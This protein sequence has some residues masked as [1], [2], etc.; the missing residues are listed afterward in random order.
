MNGNAT[1]TLNVRDVF[2]SRKRRYITEGDGF[3]AEGEFQW[4]ARSTTLTFTYRLNQ[5]KRQER[6]GRGEGGYDMDFGGS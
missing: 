5:K 4:R 3:Y 2:N 6:G 1:L